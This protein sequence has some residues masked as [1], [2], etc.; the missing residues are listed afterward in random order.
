MAGVDENDLAHIC[1]MVNG[2]QGSVHVNVIVCA[3]AC[4]RARSGILCGCKRVLLHCRHKLYC[5]A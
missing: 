2:Q 5:I 3:R 1:P 4:A